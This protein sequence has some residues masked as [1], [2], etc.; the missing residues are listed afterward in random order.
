MGL[1]LSGRKA[2]LAAALAAVSCGVGSTA[3]AGP[4]TDFASK[5]IHYY[6]GSGVNAKYN[7]AAAAL[8]GPEPVTGVG[9]AYPNIVDPFSPPYQTNQIVLLGKGGGL[10]LQLAR[11]F[12]VKNAPELGILS[13]VG[14]V[15]TSSGSVGSP[16]QIFGGGVA[17]VRVSSDN[18][19]WADLGNITF[20]LP[21][22]SWSKF[23]NEFE[24]AP[25][26]GDVPSNPGLPFTGKLSSFNGKSVQQVLKTLNGSVGGTWLN[27]SATKLKTVDYIQIRNPLGNPW[28]PGHPVQLAIDAVTVSSASFGSGQPGGGGPSAVPL[29][30]AAPAAIAMALLLGFAAKIR[31]QFVRA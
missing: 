9:T 11:A 4:T 27:V 1:S 20:N 5:V 13:N 8:G 24:P 25:A 10:T 17:D 23:S 7:D 19:T 12:T 16:A 14:L 6:Q 28:V 15:E 30:P 2:L 3:Q 21:S 22:T 26:K 29:P 31:R 18:K